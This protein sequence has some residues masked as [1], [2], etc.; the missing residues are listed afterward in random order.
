MKH[1]GFENIHYKEIVQGLDQTVY[2]L[3]F[4][5]VY[6]PRDQLHDLAVRVA[7]NAFIGHIIWGGLSKDTEDLVKQIENNKLYKSHPTDFIHGLLSSH[8]YQTSK[9][10]DKVEFTL[11]SQGTTHVDAKYNQY[12]ENWRVEK[13]FQPENAD[14]YYSVLYVN[15]KTHHAVLAHRGTD[16]P[17]FLGGQSDTV[18]ADLKEY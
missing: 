2:T 15:D 12:L 13:V 1:L 10:G 6:L 11:D 14:D 18:K 3:D 4:K 8:S 17:G 7:D 5:E 16:M 9:I